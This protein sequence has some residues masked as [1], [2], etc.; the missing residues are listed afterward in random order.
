VLHAS[1]WPWRKSYTVGQYVHKFDLSPR[2]G[3]DP[4][5]WGAM[6]MD[7]FFSQYFD[8]KPAVLE[9]FGAFDISLASD[10][11]LFIDPFL[12]FSQWMA[13]VCRRF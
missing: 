3:V 10:L 4:D 7:L 12:L 2:H 5:H 8:V 1:Q 9:E 6:R 11:P 13:L